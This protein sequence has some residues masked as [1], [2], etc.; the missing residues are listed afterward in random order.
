M[1]NDPRQYANGR[2]AV[3]PT[4]D[5]TNFRQYKR[6]VRL[7][8]S[9]TRVAPARRA[10]K[11][12]ERLEGR[13]FDSC[14]GI[15]DLETPNGVENLLDHLR[16]YFKPI[17][18][19]GQEGIVDDFV[20]LPTT[21]WRSEYREAAAMMTIA[22]QRRAEVDRARQ[23]FRKHPSSEGSKA[24]LD[25]LKQKL[26][27]AR[28]GQLGHWK[29]VHDCPAK[30]KAVTWEETEITPIYS[31]PGN[32]F[33]T[34]ERP[35]CNHKLFA[36]CS[37]CQGTSPQ[38]SRVSHTRNRGGDQGNCSS[39]LGGGLCTVSC[40][41]GYSNSVD[42]PQIFLCESDERLLH[43]FGPENFTCV[44]DVCSC[45]PNSDNSVV[46]DCGDTQL[47]TGDTCTARCTLGHVLGVRDTEQ[48]FSCQSDGVVSG[49]QPVCEPLP[50]SAPKIVSEYG[51]DVCIDKCGRKE[52]RGF[53]C[54]PLFHGGRSDC[55]DL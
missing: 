30:V 17:E 13:A 27:C 53:M 23:F 50:C 31:K 8:V 6:P 51:V 44:A 45:V 1:S 34:R 36:Q 42:L 3:V 33:I 46:S 16:M 4:F 24:R 37:R 10:G 39:K 48:S 32:L 26:P 14:E 20:R 28:C 2:G 52:L 9:N 40:V 22:K 12:L 49:T 47:R 35:V 55:V 29:D 41:S 7:F 11:L 5:G 21:S 38:R 43:I 25:K 18:V 54:E 15:Q 19:F